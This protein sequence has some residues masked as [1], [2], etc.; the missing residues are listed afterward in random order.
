MENPQRSNTGFVGA[1]KIHRDQQGWNQ[2]PKPIF[3][4]SENAKTSTI[5]PA[6]TEKLKTM[7]CHLKEP[8]TY[9]KCLNLLSC[10]KG[11]RMTSRLPRF[12][13]HRRDTKLDILLAFLI[14]DQP[15]QSH[16]QTLSSPFL[17]HHHSSTPKHVCAS[18]C[19]N[20]HLLT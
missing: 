7:T 10:F 6:F 17:S 5:S 13:G 8:H 11:S 16:Q 4:S 3:G 19:L 1:Y 14:P 9:I 2:T 12:K 15:D 18:V 20:S